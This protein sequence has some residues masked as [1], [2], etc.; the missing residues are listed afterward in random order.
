MSQS[1]LKNQY[2]KIKS[3]R[4][5][6]DMSRGK[7]GEDVTSLSNGMLNLPGDNFTALNGFDCRNYGVLDGLPEAK[8]LFAPILGV[9]HDELIIGGNSSLQM[10]YDAI[11]RAMLVGVSEE[12]MGSGGWAKQGSIKFI[13]PVPGYDRHFSICE[14]LG[15]EMLTV[16][17]DEN[18]PDMDTIEKLVSED[19]SIKGIW[20]IPIYSNPTGITYSDEVVRRFAKLKPKAN[21]FRL[22]WDCAYAVHHL[23]DTPIKLLNILEEC[24]KSDNADLVYM[25]AS[26]SKITFP[27]G[28][29]GF[30]AASKNN[31]DFIRKHMG[32]Q[33]IGTDKLNQLRH[34]QFF[35]GF[36]GIVA[37]MKKI[38]TVLKPKFDTVI[39]IL[40]RELA[41]HNLGT[42][43]TPN[44]G[45][46]I[47]FDGNEGTAKKTVQLCKEAG[48]VLTEAGAVFPYQ[49]DPLNR[50]I[51]IAPT[52]PP[53]EE[54]K[55]A[56]EIFCI[57]VKLANDFY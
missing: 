38:Q 7:P 46:F 30:M 15:I 16:S 33:T 49:N 31:C 23:T 47:S 13:C 27:G 55:S 12:T 29:V 18:G 19:D 17:M 2:D 50:N 11:T 52:L 3:Q 4:L 10:M 6:L 24:K 41:P 43:Y 48:V 53:L 20:C 34:V 1:Q 56:M 36:D 9:T 5:N 57:S 8:S 37:H 44:G 42:W 35:G 45:Y 32:F 28:G 14:S 40:E 25:F 22:F 54:L 51:R 21:D 26:T 39:E